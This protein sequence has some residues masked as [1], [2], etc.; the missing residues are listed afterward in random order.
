[1]PWFFVVFLIIL[2]FH[3]I[4]FIFRVITGGGSGR[5]GGGASGWDRGWVAGLVVEAAG[6]GVAAVE[7]D[8]VGLVVAAQE[9]VAQVAVGNRRAVNPETELNELVPRLREA[10]GSNLVSVIVYGSAA[11]KD[12]PSQLQ[13]RQRTDGRE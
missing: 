1:M 3:F 13:R 9:E 4:R 2:V 5:R 11:G 8:L 6:V 10:A 12:F 7:V